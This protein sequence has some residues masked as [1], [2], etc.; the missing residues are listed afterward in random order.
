MTIVNS[1]VQQMLTCVEIGQE[2]L[3]SKLDNG[4]WLMFHH[5]AHGPSLAWTTASVG[6]SLAEF[7]AVPHEVIK[8]ILSLRHED[9]GWSYNPSVPSDA[10]T[11][12]RVMQFLRK[13]GFTDQNIITAAET[14]VLLHQQPDGGFTTY[15]PEIVKAMGYSLCD[16]WCASQPCVTALAVNQLSDA[17]AVR[18]AKAFLQHSGSQA[19]W[20]RGPFYVLYEMGRGTNISPTDD[21]VELALALLLKSKLG[22][23]DPLLIQRLISLQHADGSMPTS[24]LFQIPRPHQMLDDLDGNEETVGDGGIFSLCATLVAVE[25]QR[26]FA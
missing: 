11:T 22:I 13:I 10:D 18:R 12:L 6:S 2:Y 25:R 9:G 20:W 14:F 16:G 1:I 19:Y 23:Y 26:H 4:L 24:Y 17:M 3:L 7:N 15:R 21:P 5:L 8:A